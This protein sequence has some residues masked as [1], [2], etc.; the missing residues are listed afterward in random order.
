V[1]LRVAVIGQAAFGA[2]TVDTLRAAGHEV[3]AVSAPRP[4]ADQAADP[5]WQK[6][7]ESGLPVIDTRDLA[8]K[9]PEWLAQF[10]PDVGVMAFVTAIIPGEVLDTPRHGTIQYH[11]SL[12]PKHRGRS[13]LNWAIIQGD[14]KT[15]LTIFWVDEG[16]DTGPIMLQREADIA[17]NDTMGSLYFDKLYP[18]GL[19]ALRDAV[20]LIEAGDAPRTAQDDSLATYEPPC[21]DEHARIDWQA[22]AQTTYNLVR[23]TNPRPGA[24]TTYKG[25]L[26]R[27]YEVELLAEHA[28]PGAIAAITDG[29]LLVG[30]NEGTLRVVRVAGADG[31]KIPA[32]Q[33]AAEVNLKPG[34]QF[35]T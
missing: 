24:H 29:A 23:G 32:G 17:P 4:A 1:S 14:T 30:L 20:D 26:L 34:D 27:V 13:A 21:E 25:N 12:L 31:R 35:G 15:G 22:P 7:E 16:I 10:S 5:L 9:Q 2:G 19:E 6:A 33:W 28:D 11:P 3:V 8:K 18:M